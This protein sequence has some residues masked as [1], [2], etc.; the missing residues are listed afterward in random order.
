M[1]MT[2]W[3]TWLG[4]SVFAFT[5][6][7]LVHFVLLSASPL[8]VERAS[9]EITERPIY[10]MPPSSRTQ[11]KEITRLVARKSVCAL[12]VS[13]LGNGEL[14]TLALGKGDPRLL[15][16]DDEDVALTGSE[17]VIYGILDVDNVETSVVTLTVGDDTNTAHVTT[18]SGHSDD[19]SVELDEV[20]DLASG[21]VN[22]DGVV[23]PDGWVWVA[24]TAGTNLSAFRGI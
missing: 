8:L 10:S 18:T 23:D 12:A 19:T 16:P 5:L 17:G 4:T 2:P 13:L 3:I 1:G 20:G 21:Q 11:S 24:D 15:R 14:D 22:L 9:T 7:V 6:M